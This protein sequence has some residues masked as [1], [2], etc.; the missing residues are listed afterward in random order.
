[1]TYSASAPASSSGWRSLAL[2]RVVGASSSWFLFA[3]FFTLLFLSGTAVIGLGGFCASGGPYE[4]AVECPDSV[5]AFTPLSIFGGLIAVGLYVFLAQGFAT[6]LTTW[7]WPILFCGL[8]VAFLGGFVLYQDITGLLIG[9]M[10]EVMGLVPLVIELRGSPQR[11]FL[12]QFAANG[13]QFYEGER[14]RRS[15]MSPNSPNPQGAVQAAPA[16]WVVGLGIPLIFAVAGVLVAKAW[17]GV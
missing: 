12:G 6:P 17:F 3:L 5:V 8:G 7:A 11:V 9:I 13:A 2:I 16:H 15:L 1:M 4:I 14:A 10:F